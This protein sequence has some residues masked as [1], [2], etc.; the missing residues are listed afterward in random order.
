MALD[1][2][3][4]PV[5]AGVGFASMSTKNSTEHFKELVCASSFG[6]FGSFLCAVVG[7]QTCRVASLSNTLVP[8]QCACLKNADT[9]LHVA[10]HIAIVKT[11]DLAHPALH[12]YGE[13]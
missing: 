12:Q 3:W 11:T 9:R 10:R 6:Q 1:L 7:V 4:W 5:P 13:H 8:Q 2:D